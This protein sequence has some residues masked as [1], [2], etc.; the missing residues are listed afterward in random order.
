MRSLTGPS[1]RLAPEL[2]HPRRGCPEPRPGAL[3]PTL[4]GLTVWTS[5]KMMDY[6]GPIIARMLAVEPGKVALDGSETAPCESEGCHRERHC[7]AL[8]EE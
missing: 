5:T 8:T 4:D 6:V 2:L 7:I 1:P 3:A